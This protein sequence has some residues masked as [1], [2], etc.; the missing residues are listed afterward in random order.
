MTNKLKILVDVDGVSCDLISKVLDK[1]NDR[2][3]TN[4]C[5]DDITTWDFFTS[6]TTIFSENDLNVIRDIFCEEGLTKNISV[7]P[8]LLNALEKVAADGH[9]I[10]WVTAPWKL[11]KTWVYDRTIWIEKELGHISKKIV[12]TW[13]KELVEGDIIIDDNPEFIKKWEA[14][15]M[16]CNGRGLL[17]K[18]PWNIKVGID[19][20]MVFLDNWE[21]SML[22]F[23]IDDQIAIQKRPSQL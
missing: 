13:N 7:M 15:P 18:A 11:S 17:F 10:I 14:V 23:M 12:F 4:Y 19:D 5:H 21:D 16:N 3:H 6:G 20:A 9:E 8:G 2:N 22:Q 1:L